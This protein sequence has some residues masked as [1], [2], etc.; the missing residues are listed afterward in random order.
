LIHG[1]APAGAPVRR[2]VLRRRGLPY[3][4]VSG[5]LWWLAAVAALAVGRTLPWAGEKF[6]PPKALPT[7]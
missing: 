6:L 2:A 5:A 7:Q 4:P 1:T 3:L